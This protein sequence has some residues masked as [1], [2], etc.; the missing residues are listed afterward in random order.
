MRRIVMFNQV[1]PEG[2]FS[3]PSGALD[4]T[5]QDDEL[6]RANASGLSGGPGAMLFGRRTYQLFEN[7][8]PKALDDEH[9]APDPHRPGERSPELRTMAVW[10]NESEKIVVSRTLKQATWKNTRLIPE[11]VPARVEALKQEP[12]G[13]IMIFGSGSIV[14]QLTAYGLIDE[15]QFVVDP[16]LLGGGRSLFGDLP[17]RVSLDLLEARAYPSGNVVLRY[18]P[19]RTS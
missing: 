16:V 9:T 18:A 5:V 11:L 6:N 17:G 7:F 1:T 8:W 4:W 12:G 3:S 15:Y 14:T 13:D 19:R 2:F 10:I